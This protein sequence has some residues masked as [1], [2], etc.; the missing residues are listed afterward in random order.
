MDELG[1]HEVSSTHSMRSRQMH[2]ASW[3]MRVLVAYFSHKLSDIEV[4][5]TRNVTGYSVR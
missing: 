1:R 4:L 3:S 5:A 2:Q